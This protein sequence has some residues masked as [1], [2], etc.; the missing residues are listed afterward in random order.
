MGRSHPQRLHGDRDDKPIPFD[1]SV[2]APQADDERN[3]AGHLLPDSVDQISMTLE[4]MSRSIKDLAR[5]LNC[6]GFFDDDDDRPK[7]A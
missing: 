6:L 7:A 2:H 4:S 5:E 3:E 1:E